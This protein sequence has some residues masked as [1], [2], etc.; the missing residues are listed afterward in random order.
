MNK[1][2]IAMFILPYFLH[3]ATPKEKMFK[4]HYFGPERGTCY[5]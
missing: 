1:K 4:K 2:L 3:H 5:E